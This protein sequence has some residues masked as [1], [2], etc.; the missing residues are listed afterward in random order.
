MISECS[1]N[2]SP[3]YDIPDL[4]SLKATLTPTFLCRQA[5][6]STSGQVF[7]NIFLFRETNPVHFQYF[8]SFTIKA[9]VYF[10][11]REKQIRFQLVTFAEVTTDCYICTVTAE[12]LLI[13]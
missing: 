10:L 8:T 13:C 3:P 12:L 1:G 7:F 4:F 2:L 6:G 5:E 9:T 11:Q